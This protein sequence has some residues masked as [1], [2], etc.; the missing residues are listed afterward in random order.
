MVASMSEGEEPVAP[1]VDGSLTAPE[2]LRAA[3]EK[4]GMS[5]ADVAQTTRVPQRHLEALE[6]G[7]YTSL[8]SITYCT[9]FARA[10][11]RAVGM[12][13]VE[14]VAKVREE[15]SSGDERARIAYAYDEAAD[16]ARVPPR[17]LAIAALILV[18][19]LMGGYAI[20]RTQMNSP[21]VEAPV[22]APEPSP[23]IASPVVAPQQSPAANAASTGP[24]VLTA[25]DDVWLRVYEQDG[26]RYFDQTLGKGQSFTVPAD[27]SNPLILTGRPDAIAVTV[28]GRAV[29][30]L[31]AAERTIADVPISAAALLA[32]DANSASAA[33]TVQQATDSAA[34]NNAGN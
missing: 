15:V 5:L 6:Q 13:P 9:G 31:G 2:M 27:A 20:W 4:A 18:V 29:P 19:L 32:R 22:V 7:E 21:P 30:P 25:M 12:D 17:W 11:A 16:P 14:V 8:P 3:R 34:G 26:R 28:G 1:S 23:A 33:A 10:Y 24:V